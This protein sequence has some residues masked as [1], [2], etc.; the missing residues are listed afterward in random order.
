MLFGKRV[1]KTH[2]RVVACGAVDE[3]NATLG[4]VRCYDLSEEMVSWIDGVQQRLVALMGELMTAEEDHERYAAAGY[5][6][7]VKSDIEWLD[8]L[9][10]DLEDS[11]GVKFRGWSRPGEVGKLAAASL[12]LA[13]TTCRRAERESWAIEDGYLAKPRAF[14]NRLSDVLWLLARVGEK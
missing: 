10:R 11:K 6:Q 2:E 8:G 5:A 1:P 14:L 12:H 13:R 9:V 4:V 3:L 7:I